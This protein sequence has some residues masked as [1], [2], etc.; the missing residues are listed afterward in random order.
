[1]HST[2]P[3][4]CYILYNS[5]YR[6]FRLAGFSSCF[7]SQLCEQFSEVLFDPKQLERHGPIPPYSQGKLTVL[8]GEGGR[9]E[10]IDSLRVRQS[11]CATPLEFKGV[12][13]FAYCCK[14]FLIGFTVFEALSVEKSLIS[15]QQLSRCFNMTSVLDTHE[16]LCLE[17]NPLISTWEMPNFVINMTEVGNNVIYQCYLINLNDVSQHPITNHQLVQQVFFHL[18][19]LPYYWFSERGRTIA[20]CTD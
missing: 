9:I 10:G 11:I 19:I 14:K 4:K 16:V 7:H 6:L 12:I 2:Y 17:N 1:M 8:G 18:Q 3:L 15:F 5:T 13:S 20:Q